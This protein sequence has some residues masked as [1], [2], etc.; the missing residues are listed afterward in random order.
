[1][2]IS[3]LHEAQATI[4]QAL[5]FVPSARFT[6]LQKSTGLESDHF[7]FH[8]NR[9]MTL[10]SVARTEKGL[11]SLTI[12]GKRHANTKQQPKLSVLLNVARGEGVGTEFLLQE[13]LKHPHFGF[14]GRPSG[15]VEW[16]ESFAAAAE[17]VLLKETGLRATFTFKSVL[18]KRDIEE[19]TQSLLEDKVFVVM[20]A[21]HVKGE[22]AERF[23]GGCNR[24]MTIEEIN[25]FDKSK[26]FSSLSQFIERSE[27]V[28]A[29]TVAYY[30]NDEY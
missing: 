27:T 10:G 20:Q 1:M 23:E 29:E 2:T 16:G 14:L 22:L 19:D 26:L 7:N 9:L 21:D 18:R 3:P 6:D 12:Q 4:V 5:L 28:F 8:I 17:R 15:R 13:R 24:W 25:K 30:R 11:Y